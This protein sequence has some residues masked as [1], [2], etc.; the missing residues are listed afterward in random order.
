[1]AEEEEGGLLQKALVVGGSMALIGATFGVAVYMFDGGGDDDDADD[2]RSDRDSDRRHSKKAYSE[3][4]ESE[5]AH[6]PRPAIERGA[7]EMVEE[8]VPIDD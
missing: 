8:L 4:R 5:R 3:R 7:Y 6:R 2:R 1:M